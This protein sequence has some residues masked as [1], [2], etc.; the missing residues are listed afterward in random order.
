MDL[1]T[2]ACC[3]MYFIPEKNFRRDILYIL[4]ESTRKNIMFYVDDMVFI[5]SIDYSI[6]NEIDTSKYILS[7][8]R[9]ADLQT[10]F[11]LNKRHEMPQFEEFR[12]GLFKF[13]WNYTQELNA[14]TFPLGVSGFMFGKAEIMLMIRMIYFNAP[15]SLERMLQRFRRYFI[16]RYGLCM[17]KTPCACIHANLVQS[18]VGG[19]SLNLYTVDDLLE[20]WEQGKEINVDEFEGLDVEIAQ[21]KKYNFNNR[22]DFK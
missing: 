18:E 9:G 13:R 20:L 3:L 15:N 14:F 6:F 8:S 4:K 21:L 2:A 17:E 7:L 11:T 19:R 16:N 12:D 5:R 10:S 22:R 1:T